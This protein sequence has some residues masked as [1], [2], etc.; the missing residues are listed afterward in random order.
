MAT[1]LG[2]VHDCDVTGGGNASI[3]ALDEFRCVKTLNGNVKNAMNGTYHAIG[4]AKYAYR[5]LAEVQLSFNR[6][7]DMSGM[8]RQLLAPMVVTVMRPER[9]VRVVEFGCRVWSIVR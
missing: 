8:L 9:R 1:T 4:F 3:A 5:Y 6:R 7:Y 2:A